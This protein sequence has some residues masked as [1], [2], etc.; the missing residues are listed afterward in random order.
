MT[1]V[2]CGSG[3]LLVAFF[4]SFSCLFGVGAPRLGNRSSRSRISQTSVGGTPKVTT[5]TYYFGHFFRKTTSIWKKM[6]ARGWGHLGPTL[7]IVAFLQ[8]FFDFFIFASTFVRCE[9]ALT[10]VTACKRSLGQGNVF[11]RLCHYVT[12]KG[13]CPWCYFLSLVPCSFRGT[14]VRGVSVLC[15][16]QGC[17][18]AGTPVRWTS[19]RYAS[20]WNA[21]LFYL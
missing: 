1:V 6:E 4:F 18:Y 15:P 8:V 9:W 20:Y 19:G 17:L 3:Y 11:T 5:Q 2:T 16:G 13:L 21:F 12:G 10:I 7:A 14:S